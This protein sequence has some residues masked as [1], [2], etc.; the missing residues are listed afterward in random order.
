MIE[1]CPMILGH[2]SIYSFWLDLEGPL[3]SNIG[4]LRHA[5][6]LRFYRNLFNGT[7][8]SFSPNLCPE[9]H[10]DALWKQSEQDSRRGIEGWSTSNVHNS[11]L[12]AIYLGKV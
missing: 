1:S 4:L 6:E 9:R 11:K 2:F 12:K 10:S 3:P 7:I 8:P 5:Q